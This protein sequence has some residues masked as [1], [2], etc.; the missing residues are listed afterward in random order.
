MVRYKIRIPAE[1]TSYG[2]LTR[3]PNPTK[4]HTAYYE[5]YFSDTTEL[6]NDEMMAIF[7][8]MANIGGIG[9]LRVEK[10]G[11]ESK[12]QEEDQ[13]EELL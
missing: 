13:S 6:T 8:K 7:D 9:N 2:Y 12:A 3:R 10:F 11:D 4:I 1:V 5:V